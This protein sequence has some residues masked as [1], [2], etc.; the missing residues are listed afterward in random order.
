MVQATSSI[1]RRRVLLGLGAL[2]LS[3]ACA[4]QSLQASGDQCAGQKAGSIPK[5][6]VG[7][8]VAA[9]PESVGMSAD[10]IADV[11]ARLDRRVTDGLIP[12]GT[13]MIVRGGKIVGEHAFGTK[14]RGT[15]EP[16]TMDTM[17][18]LLSVTKVVSTSVSAMVLIDRGKLKL[19]DPV[20]KH[21]PGFTGAGKDKVTVKQMLTYSAG[22]PVEHHIFDADPKVI[23][24]RMA[25]L[26][27]E[28]EPGTKVEYSDLTYR[29]LGKVIEAAAGQTLDE[30][31][32]DNVWKPLGMVDT[33]Y[34]PPAALQSRIAAT[35]TT[36]HRKEIL[37]GVVQ[38]DQDHA[39]G[40]VAG[41]DGVFS[42]ARDLAVFGQMVLNGGIYAGKRIVSEALAAEMVKNQTP[43]VE[44][45]K[46]DISPLVNLLAAPKA[47][48]WEL[49]TPRFSSGGMRLSPG[50]YGK[51]GGTGCF[52]W[53]DPKRQLFGVLLTNYGMPFPFDEREWDR[54][55]DNTGPV[56][57]FDGM[58][59]AVTD[60]G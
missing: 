24:N 54:L 17:F 51:T 56:E 2:F 33:M 58:I 41:C 37:R 46:V 26:K 14:V 7:P 40:G 39:I 42:T 4:S 21:L 18:D 47:Y 60:E 35:N 34:N 19:D 15:K 45:A 8:L 22:L 12:G 38:D 27:L 59:D 25:Q 52:V 29:L 31:A 48:G 50:S 10:R 49:T 16:V 55:I 30:F 11:F 6:D 9:K 5:G 20:V 1:D 57:F 3:P 43:F 23:L 36:E 32:R 28:Y 13:A 53:V 44:T